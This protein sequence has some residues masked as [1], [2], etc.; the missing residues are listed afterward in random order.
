MPA[1]LYCY[2]VECQTCGTVEEWN[3]GVDPTGCP[4]DPGHT[5]DSHELVR[6]ANTVILINDDAGRVFEITA[7]QNGT[8]STTQITGPAPV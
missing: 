8:L 7:D 1:P 2:N 6:A 3:A 4:T 5:I